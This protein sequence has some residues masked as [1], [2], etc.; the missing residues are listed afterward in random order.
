MAASAFR[1]VDIPPLSERS[2]QPALERVASLAQPLLRLGLTAVARLPPTS[3]LRRRA[4]QEGFVRGFA[5]TN[6]HDDWHVALAYEPDCEFHIDAGFRTL[7]LADSYRGRE[8]WRELIAAVAEGLPDVRWTP[9]HV[10]D[11]GDRLVLRARMT[12]SGRASGARTQQTWGS[13][14]QLSP[15]GRVAR[16]EVHWTWEQTLA[17]AGLRPSNP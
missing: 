11:L 7:G 4:L 15:R 16:E 6:R 12:G 1:G 17:A 9:E 14:Y 3:R 2:G 8:G 13:V 5:A 10:I